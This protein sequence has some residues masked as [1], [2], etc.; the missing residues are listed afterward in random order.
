MIH[1]GQSRP[2]RPRFPAAARRRIDFRLCSVDLPPAILL[3]RGVVPDMAGMVGSV[4]ARSSPLPF[5]RWTDAS[6]ALISP[7][8]PQWSTSA[9]HGR[10]F[11]KFGSKLERFPPP[12]TLMGSLAGIWIGIASASCCSAS[13]L[14]A[15]SHLVTTTRCTGAWPLRAPYFE[16]PRS[17]SAAIHGTSG[18]S[19]NS[20]LSPRRSLSEP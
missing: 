4:A 14:N 13:P 10:S 2:P 5:P 12:Q 15:Y 9:V 18:T 7:S 20:T 16:R 17:M 1:P 6:I 3:P 8:V 11:R 19:T